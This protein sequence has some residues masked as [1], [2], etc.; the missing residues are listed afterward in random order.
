M[1]SADKSRR[2]WFLVV[3]S[4]DGKTEY[5][6]PLDWDSTYRHIE[7]ILGEDIEDLLGFTLM[8]DDWCDPITIKSQEDLQDALQ[9]LSKREIPDGAKIKCR[10]IKIP[11]M[12]SAS[13]A[14][15]AASFLPRS[16]KYSAEWWKLILARL[17]FAVSNFLGI[18]MAHS[19]PPHPPPLYQMIVATA[20]LASGLVLTFEGGKKEIPKAV[21]NNNKRLLV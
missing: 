4:L 21:Q 5:H 15:W 11:L 8:L 14:K 3:P 7:N 6:Y 20:F 17:I 1:S 16:P 12:S 13:I 19:P 18:W 9:Y 2:R 10:A